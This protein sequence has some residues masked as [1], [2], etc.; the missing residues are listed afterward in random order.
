ME[1]NQVKKTEVVYDKAPISKRLLAYFFDISIWLLTSLIVFTAVNSI[2]NQ[3]S[4]YKTK[5]NELTSIR[6]ESKMYV[7]GQ[8]ITSYVESSE[9]FT[10]TEQKKEFL[11]QSIDAFY[12]NT[13]FFENTNHL[14]DYQSRKTKAN[15]GDLKLFKADENNQIIENDVLPAYLLDFYK[16]E[17]NDYALGYLLHD[18]RYFDLTRFEFLKVIVEAVVVA[19]L[20]FIVYFLVLPVT[21]FNRGRQSL[22][23]KLARIG[24]VNIHALTPSFKHYFLRFLFNLFIGLYLNIIS[25]LIPSFVTI[26]MM[27]L[28]KT[29][30]GLTNYVFNDYFVDVT[31]QHIYLDE[32]ERQSSKTNLENMSIENKDLLLK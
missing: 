5:A 20:F 16:T 9:E 2:V 18:A 14:S 27:F 3:T 23:M 29:N 11:S 10:S 26:G 6:A 22:G 13:R 21:C 17:I 24:L 12:S 1:T 28:T 25:F 30:Q 8:V 4:F 19:T 32:G 7:D 15:K 31:N